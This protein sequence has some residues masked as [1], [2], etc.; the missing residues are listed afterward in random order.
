MFES[1]TYSTR[2]AAL[3]GVS[4]HTMIAAALAMNPAW[5]RVKLPPGFFRISRSLN[6]IG[7]SH[8]HFR[9]SGVGIST[10]VADEDLD[11]SDNLHRNDVIQALNFDAWDP[12]RGG[13]PCRNIH[14]SDLT[15]DCWEQNTSGITA[16]IIAGKLGHSLAGIEI[17]NVDDASIQRVE[18]LGAYGNGAVISTADPRIYDGGG[19]RV[20]IRNP[21]MRDLKLTDCLRGLLPQYWGPLTPDGITGTAIQVG[22]CVGG[23]ISDILIERPSGP[24]IDRFN[25]RGLSMERITVDGF[26]MFPVG[27]SMSSKTPFQQLVGGIRSDFGLIDCTLRDVNFINTGGILDTGSPT[28]FFQNAET[29][30]PG[31]S[32]CTYDGIRLTN[33]A[34]KLQLPTPPLGSAG[35][36]IR[37]R[38]PTEHYTYPVVVTLIGGEGVTGVIH[39]PNCTPQNLLIQNEKFV[40]RLNDLVQLNW[41]VKPTS[42]LWHLAPNLDFA[43]ICLQGGSGESVNQQAKDNTINDVVCRE[44]AGNAIALIDTLNTRVSATTAENSGLMGAVQPVSLSASYQRAGAGCHGT[45]L[46]GITGRET[47]Y[48]YTG[49]VYE[50]AMTSGTSRTNVV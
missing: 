3:S 17:M 22:S 14:V 29:P 21:I 8:I 44:S 39:R 27:A 38:G 41:T 46:S 6:F 4:L 34:G 18:V 36:L 49:P 45:S 13:Y 24:A 20:G 5:L 30:T 19:A 48:A 50:D 33:P 42:W 7:K 35:Q 10:I 37:H 2:E 15:I 43:G 9:G 23:V 40:M 31:P 26:G 16:G 32:G 11:G 25:C 47:R 1:V 12:I 28:A